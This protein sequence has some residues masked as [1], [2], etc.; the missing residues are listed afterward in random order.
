[1]GE[2]ESLFVRKAKMM[3]LIIAAYI[4][5]VGCFLFP[6]V[7]DSL[8]FEVSKLYLILAS[9]GMTGYYLSKLYRSLKT[10]FLYLMILGLTILGMV[11][12]Y[13][14]EFGEVSNQVNF[15]IGNVAIFLIFI[16]F[17][18]MLFY[19]IFSRELLKLRKEK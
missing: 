14:L 8:S 3:K 18:M 15:T 17:A 9:C 4:V 2:K 16:P 11:G 5:M 19:F 7:R 10:V 6:M 13:I 12:R 1:M